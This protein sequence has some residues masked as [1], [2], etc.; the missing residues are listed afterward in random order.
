MKKFVSC[1]AVLLVLCAFAWT[2]LAHAGDLPPIPLTTS[3]ST[4]DPPAHM[5]G[6]ADGDKAITLKDATVLSRYLAGGW[7]VTIDEQS[8]DVNKDGSID[9]KDV[10]VIRRY[11]AGGWN[12]TL[13]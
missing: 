6:D 7:N 8:S 12:I 10:I 3:S 5:L 2:I 11:L 1:V 9:L 4:V 13:G